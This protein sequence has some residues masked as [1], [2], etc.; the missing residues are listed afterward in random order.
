MR[1]QTSVQFSLPSFR[2]DQAL[3]GASQ[4]KSQVQRKCQEL[5]KRSHWA[6]YHREPPRWQFKPPMSQ[7]AAAFSL[8]NSFI[9]I[10]MFSTHLFVMK[11]LLFIGLIAVAAWAACNKNPTP[12][13]P[14]TALTGAPGLPTQAQ[15]KLQTI[16][17]WLG[18]AELSTEMALTDEQV[19][20]GMMFRTN[21]DEMAGMIFVFPR[22]HQ[23]A[24]WMKNCPLPLSC[25]YITPDGTIAEIHDLQAQD[26]NAVVADSDQIQFVLEVNQG[27]FTRHNVKPG[28][29]VRT[30]RGTLQE[31]F[32]H[33][34]Q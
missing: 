28:T 2:I 16:R 14:Q 4:S 8:C 15:P 33:P 3:F 19:T 25:A 31:T 9:E 32:F 11:R 29:S 6:E 21:M 5:P 7:S 24:F 26:T 18:S 30:E 1:L 23:V 12:P 10:T 34:N 13:P 22:P 27:W 17:L 20:T